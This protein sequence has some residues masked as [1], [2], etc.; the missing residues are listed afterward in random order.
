MIFASSES[1]VFFSCITELVFFLIKMNILANTRQSK[2]TTKMVLL[3]FV[4]LSF[5]FRV[6]Q[7]YK[8]DFLAV[9]KVFSFT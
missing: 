8:D 5:F 6:M 1:E 7:V 3:V 9:F 2:T 4:V